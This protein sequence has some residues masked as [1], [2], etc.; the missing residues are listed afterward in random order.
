[1]NDLF[2]DA[3]AAALDAADPLRALR[4]DFLIPRHDGAPMAY[5][6]GNSLGL[7][8]RGARAHVEAML[9]KWEH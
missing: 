2:S 9:G 3:H 6:V 5:F 4:D 1:M 7:Q 8:P